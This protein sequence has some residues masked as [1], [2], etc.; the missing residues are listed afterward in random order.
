MNIHAKYVENV[1]V[2]RVARWRVKAG[3]RAATVF[4]VNVGQSSD[5]RVSSAEPAVLIHN[6]VLQMART[7]NRVPWVLTTARTQQYPCGARTQLER[8]RL[9][10]ATPL[11]PL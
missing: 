1:P 9:S 8:W 7:V 2:C 11:S 10:E 4:L 6:T 5:G 3:S